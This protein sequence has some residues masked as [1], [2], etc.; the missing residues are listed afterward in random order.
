MCS[1]IKQ[2]GPTPTASEVLSHFTELDVDGDVTSPRPGAVGHSFEPDPTSAGWDTL[3]RLKR[4]FVQFRDKAET[5][6]PSLFH[7]LATVQVSQEGWWRSSASAS[8]SASERAGG[9]G[10]LLLTIRRR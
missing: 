7:N 1:L 10:E 6:C 8:A 4:G 9:G 2:V 5:Y 3:R